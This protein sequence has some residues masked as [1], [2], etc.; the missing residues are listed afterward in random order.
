MQP[1][2]HL[3]KHTCVRKTQR[4]A[5]LRILRLLA[6]CQ[7]LRDVNGQLEPEDV[8]PNHQSLI[9]FSRKGFI[10]RMPADTFTPQVGQCLTRAGAVDSILHIG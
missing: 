10:K 2:S 1:V 4:A 8:I 6:A 3:E 7:V 5:I 9:L